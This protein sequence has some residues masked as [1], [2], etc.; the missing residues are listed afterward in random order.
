MTRHCWMCE[1]IMKIKI[2]SVVISSTRFNKVTHS[3]K[4]CQFSRVEY[5]P[6]GTIDD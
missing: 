1:K 3:C 2:V 5:I 4:G 6:M